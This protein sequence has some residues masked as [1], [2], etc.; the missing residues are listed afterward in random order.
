MT[1]A[2]VNGKKIFVR[3]LVPRRAE[4]STPF[5]VTETAVVVAKK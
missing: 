1:S 2:R 4:E 5:R 3:G